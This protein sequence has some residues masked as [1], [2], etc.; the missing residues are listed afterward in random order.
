MPTDQVLFERRGRLGVIVLNRP[1]NINAL[2]PQMVEAM[3]AK[4]GEWA[5]DDAVRTVLVRGAGE[6][7]LCAGGD[8]VAIY[9]DMIDDGGSATAQFWAR[10]YRLNSL[11][12]RY[13]KP[14]VA[15]MDGLVLGGG[16]G[17]S[18]HGSHRIITERT[19][20]GM[21]ETTIGFVPDVGGTFLLAAATGE[22]GT[23]AA[24]TGAHLDGADALHLGLADHFVRSDSLDALATALEEEA[25]DEVIAKFVVEPQPSSLAADRTWIDHAYAADDVEE[26]V[27]RLRST[28]VP[29]AAQAADSIEAK[30]PTALKVTL[31]ALRRARARDLTLEEALDVEYRIGLRFLAG[32]DF[33]EGIRARVIDKDRS[34]RWN[35]ATAADVTI[36]MVADCFAS[37]GRRELGLAEGVALV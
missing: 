20:M 37:L 27:R 16:V 24:L 33:R 26:I 4:L 1:R 15:F 3:L 10:E 9:R 14:Y 29:E 31:E 22:S 6:R 5:K 7:G 18:A 32:H 11:I 35:P 13:P 8:I 2:T 25:A 23:H 19:R 30:S 17:I 28:P 36:T 34:P 12:S 21:P